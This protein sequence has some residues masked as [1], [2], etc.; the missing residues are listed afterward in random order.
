MPTHRPGRRP[1][2]KDLSRPSHHNRRDPAPRL[3]HRK[4]DTMFRAISRWTLLLAALL[5]LSAAAPAAQ[6]QAQL[7]TLVAWGGDYAGQVSGT[8]TTG[9]YSAVSAGNVHSVAIRS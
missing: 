8:P 6:A 1:A 3:Q 9:T 4:R 7:Q 5:C 2:G